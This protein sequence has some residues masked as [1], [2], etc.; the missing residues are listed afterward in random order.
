MNSA[1]RR[2]LVFG[3][4]CLLFILALFLRTSTA[5]IVEDLMADFAIPEDA[6]GLLASAIFYA[7]SMSQLPV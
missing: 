5:V 4:F 7:Y 1:A 2:E 6:L 3:V